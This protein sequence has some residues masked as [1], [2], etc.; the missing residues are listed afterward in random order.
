MTA[1]QGTSGTNWDSGFVSAARNCGSKLLCN[2]V[3][4][5]TARAHLRQLH[6]L[7]SFYS[8]F[9]ET[10]VTVQGVTYCNVTKSGDN[11]A[12]ACH[13]F[14]D[15]GLAAAFRCVSVA[16]GCNR[17]RQV[18]GFPGSAGTLLRDVAL[19]GEVTRRRHHCRMW[20]PAKGANWES[21]SGCRHCKFRERKPCSC[22]FNVRDAIVAF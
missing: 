21:V 3:R 9:S 13:S 16:S 1:L 10:N 2:Y 15:L 22:S 14:Q 18:R 6:A 7:L 19:N 4:V 8:A 5:H 20:V 12:Q 11:C 17:A